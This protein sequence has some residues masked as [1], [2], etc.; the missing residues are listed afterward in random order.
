MEWTPAQQQVLEHRGGWL[1]VQG[2]AGSGKSTVLVE[3]WRR[4]SASGYPGRVLV[5]CRSRDAAGR[6]GRVALG[7]RSWAAEG[8]PFT[9]VYG[10]ALD[11]VRRH[12]GER[13]LLPRREQWTVV[14]RMLAEDDVARWP[15]CPDFVGRSAFVD[16]VAAAVAA[17]EAAGVADDPVLAVAEACGQGRRWMDL[18]AFRHRYRQVTAAMGALDG[19]QVFTEAAEV[20]ADEQ[21]AAVESARWDEVLIDDA[22]ALTGPMGRL[23]EV[24]APGRLVAAGVDGCGID[25]AGW[26]RSGSM[27]AGPRRWFEQFAWPAAVHLDVRHRRPVPAGLL[28]CR[29]PSTEPDAIAGVLLQSHGC[30]V[31]WGD[32]AV[33]VRSER[34]RAQGIG[35]ALARH[36][37]P[38][39]VIPGSP[40]AEPAVRALTDFFAWAAGD[41]SVLD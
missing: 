12:R 11:L 24:L 3:R 27:W 13:R 28:R 41:Q 26:G 7:D 40:A 6:F 32:M 14:R 4:A 36:G 22:D 31:A 25:G 10:A 8:L 33:L 9:T 15:S 38:V 30:G 37:I 34:Q 18:L 20:L 19:F 5:L 2:P 39:R 29:H 1:Q 16:E 17:V 35:R 21:V 23:I